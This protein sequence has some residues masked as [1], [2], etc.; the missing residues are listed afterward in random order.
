MCEECDNIQDTSIAVA[1]GE[2]VSFED[3][4]YYLPH[5]LQNRD[6]R[7]RS[8]NII[9]IIYSERN[10]N[11]TNIIVILDDDGTYIVDIDQLDK[12]LQNELIH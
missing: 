1:R 8:I 6:I 7:N 5:I 4:C 11:G 12:E 10:G 2:D 9:P 3:L